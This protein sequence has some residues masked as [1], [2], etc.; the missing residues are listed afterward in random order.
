MVAVLR[1]YACQISKVFST[2]ATTAS[3]VSAH[4]FGIYYHYDFTAITDALRSRFS[5]FPHSFS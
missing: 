5:L 2:K 4:K 3:S 1:F